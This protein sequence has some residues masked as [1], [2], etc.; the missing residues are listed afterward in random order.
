MLSYA[1]NTV[2]SIA[3]QSQDHSCGT[4][5]F[6]VDMSIRPPLECH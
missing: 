3:I 5:D 6:P 1:Y 4:S 2:R